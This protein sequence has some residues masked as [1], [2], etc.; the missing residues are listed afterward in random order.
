MSAAPTQPSTA[1]HTHLDSELAI[2]SADDAVEHALDS[3]RELE[4]ACRHLLDG[5]VVGQEV[6]A[7]HEP[8]ALAENMPDLG[9]GGKGQGSA[10]RAFALVC[11]KVLSVECMRFMR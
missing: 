2:L 6:V 8:V 1:T 7:H 10:M 4:L 3:E 5:R 9:E 11:E